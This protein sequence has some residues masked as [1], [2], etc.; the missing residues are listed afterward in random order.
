MNEFPEM[1]VHEKEWQLEHHKFD[2]R[3]EQE[4]RENPGLR[5]YIVEAKGAITEVGAL[6]AYSVATFQDWK[7]TGQ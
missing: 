2:Q 4:L 7:E 6:L 1:N 3:I 5:K